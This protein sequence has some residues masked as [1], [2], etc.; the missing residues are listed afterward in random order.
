MTGFGRGCASFSGGEFQVE[1]TSINRKQL[2]VRTIIPTEFAAD[3]NLLRKLVANYISRGQVYIKVSVAKQATSVSGIEVDK[4]SLLKLIEISK[5]MR[6]LA[7]LSSEVDVETLMTI[8]NIVLKG[9]EL[10]EEEHAVAVEQ[11]TKAAEAALAQF[12]AMRLAEG[13]ALKADFANRLDLLKNLLAEIIP[14][15]EDYPDRVK[16]KLLERLAKE[17]LPVEVTDEQLLK[18]VLYYTDRADVTE[19]ITRL[20]S[21]FSQ[22]ETF[23]NT[24]TPVGRQMDF[25]MQEMFREITTLGNKAGSSEVSPKVIAFKSEL[26]KIRE[27]V[28]NV[29]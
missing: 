3:D 28:Q 20:R 26:E 11:L 27:Q 9:N 4:A 1:V 8:P 19:E 13:E 21:H 18:E 5:D 24:E 12:Q 25:L 22:F 10:S 23:L 29:E 2:E 17:N 15:V 16:A 7:G 6:S 14:Y